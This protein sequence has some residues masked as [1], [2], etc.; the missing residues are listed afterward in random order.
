MTNP[1]LDALQAMTESDGWRQLSEYIDAEWGAVGFAAKVAG[2][3]G[4][5]GM[6]EKLAINQLQQAVV[7]QKSVMAIKEWP[8]KR[9]AYLKG[10]QAQALASGSMSR[11]GPGL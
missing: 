7:A 10:L 6:D 11:R 9:I 8:A 4:N 3:I 1:E 2:T 5:P